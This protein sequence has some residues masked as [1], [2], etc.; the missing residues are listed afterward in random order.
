MALNDI[1]DYKDFDLVIVDSN[2]N[3][4][5][6][7]TSD[8]SNSE[9][10]RVSVYTND[11]WSIYISR[12]YHDNEDIDPTVNLIPITGALTISSQLGI[13]IHQTYSGC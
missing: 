11:Y 8:F 4:V 13:T 12:R 6:Q 10:I 9:I 7:T 5:A 3:I 2:Y 1:S